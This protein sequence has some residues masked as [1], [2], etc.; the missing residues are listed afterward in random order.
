MLEE[1][2]TYTRTYR[3]TD[4]DSALNCESGDLLVLAT[5]RLIALLENAAMLCVSDRLA[6]GDTTVG[7]YVELSHLKPTA[8][9]SEII[10]A[11]K[12]ER[13]VGRKL[14]FAISATEGDKS[15]GSGF[16]IR[17]VVNREKFMSAL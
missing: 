1:G 11:A 10:V 6:E 16:H 3:V 7:G 8:I 2:L 17:V 13:I 4:A 14:H 12:L 15:I 5:P 9:G